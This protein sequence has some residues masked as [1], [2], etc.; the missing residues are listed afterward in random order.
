MQRRNVLLPQPLGPMMQTHFSR[1]HREVDAV[2]HEFAAE[3]LSD[4]LNFQKR[5]CGHRRQ[6]VAIAGMTATARPRPV[7]CL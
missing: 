5:L 3:T 6:R 2:E 7:R 4:T 1:L